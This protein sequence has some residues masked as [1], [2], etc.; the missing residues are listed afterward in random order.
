LPDD[1]LDVLL[2]A[3]LNRATFAEISV[4]QSLSDLTSAIVSGSLRFKPLIQAAFLV[5]KP[6]IMC[7]ISGPRDPSGGPGV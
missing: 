5:Y 4:A 2:I 3:I 1:A 7:P 6:G